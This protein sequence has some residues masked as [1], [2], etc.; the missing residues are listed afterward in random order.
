[1]S[2]EKIDALKHHSW[3]WI[4]SLFMDQK[5]GH[6]AMSL[7]RLAFVAMLLQAQ[8][9]W[10]GFS[11]QTDLAPGQLTVLL[12]LLGYVIGSKAIDLVKLIKSS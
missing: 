3:K 1:M 11:D 12:S 4:G 10:S 6:Q 7:G 9:I 8:W 2:K 5:N